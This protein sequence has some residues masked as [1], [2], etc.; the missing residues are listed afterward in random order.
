VLDRDQLKE[1]FPDDEL[2]T[3]PASALP[4]G[5]TDDSARQLLT[6]VGIPE[7]FLEVLELDA[8]MAERFET[9]AEVYQHYGEDPPQGV[10][11]LYYLGF[12]GQPFL[13]LHGKTGEVFQV[14]RN[15]GV[16]PLA[17]SLESFVRV[18]GS[19]SDAVR[20]YQDRRQPDAEG[21]AAE[22]TRDALRQL[23]RTD[24]AALPEAEPAWRNFLSDIAANAS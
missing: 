2:L 12:A 16:R 3:V 10:D 19:V 1:W 7:S 22:L 20:T 9:V 15:S 6:E 24:P 5:L 17:S 11:N 13:A 21:F 4:A 18:L 23:G 8:N 14:H